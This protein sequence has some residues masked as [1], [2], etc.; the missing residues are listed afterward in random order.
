VADQAKGAQ[1]ID[2]TTNTWLLT[3]PQTQSRGFDVALNPDGSLAYTPL[4]SNVF[5]L[6]TATNAWLQTITGDF[7]SLYQITVTP[8]SPSP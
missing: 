2:A 5:V 8:G 4:T 3:M 7:T 1:V 6:D